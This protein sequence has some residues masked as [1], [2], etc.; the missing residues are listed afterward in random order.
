M[1]RAIVIGAT[2]GIGRE[3]AKL[4]SEN[5]YK[6]GI[7]GRRSELLEELNRTNPETFVTRAF[8]IRKYNSI[9]ENL[10]YLEKS[11]GGLDLLIISSGT[12]KVRDDLDFENEENTILTN[13]LGFTYIA[14]WAMNYF[15]K[16]KHGH[17]IA[18]S[19]IAGLRGNRF[20]PAYGATKAF[21][22]NYLE[23]LRARMTHLKLPVFVTD[24]RPG[25][26]DTAMAQGD[27]IFWVATVKK[28]GKQIF[29]AIQKK[30]KVVYVSKRWRI[31]AYVLKILPRWIHQ[32][33]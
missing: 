5:N 10:K 31:F 2:S 13:A 18:I 12:G 14:D 23:A 24:V 8:D 17:L 30:R 25:F 26:V 21:Q 20:S 22:M 29:N 3:L 15:E 9:E 4:L 28:A 1:K 6:V 33:I 19:S 16:Q 27:N 7:T 11:L 32:K